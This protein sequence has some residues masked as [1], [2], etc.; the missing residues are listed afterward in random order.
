MYHFGSFVAEDLEGVCLKVGQIFSPTLRWWK[1]ALA[2]WVQGGISCCL[3]PGCP[4]SQQLVAKLG[5]RTM[6]H[7]DRAAAF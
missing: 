5:T 6:L 1:G 7:A 4:A 3:G 2:A